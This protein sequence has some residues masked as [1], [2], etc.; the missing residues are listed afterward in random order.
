MKIVW[1]ERKMSDN[2]FKEGTCTNC[3]L[4]QNCLIENIEKS[5][6]SFWKCVYCDE[7]HTIRKLK[8]FVKSSINEKGEGQ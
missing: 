1:R 5:P 2:I 7:I 8:D 6:V 3:G 4:N